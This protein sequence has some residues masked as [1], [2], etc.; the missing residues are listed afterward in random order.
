MAGY[1][2]LLP[3][4][5]H[6]QN[7]I[8]G[9]GHYQQNVNGHGML[10]STNPQQTMANSMMS[11]Q[12]QHYSQ[13]P[14]QQQQQQ[15]HMHHQQYQLQYPSQQSLITRHLMG[16]HHHHQML[17]GGSL[18][19]QSRSLLHHNGLSSMPPSVIPLNASKS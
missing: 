14:Q 1:R 19:S 3:P 4:Q 15:M 10:Y 8:L 7:A 18:G 9:S 17:G 6:H 2:Q 16:H 11:G 13:S 5:S 12:N